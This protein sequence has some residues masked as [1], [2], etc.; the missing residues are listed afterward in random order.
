MM[1]RGKRLAGNTAKR[2]Q[3]NALFG[4]LTIYATKKN[5]RFIH[6]RYGYYRTPETQ[7]E[8]YDLKRSSMDGVKRVSKHQVHLARDIYIINEKNQ[9]VFDV[10]PYAVLGEFW[11]ALGGKW[12]GNFQGSIKADIFHFE[13]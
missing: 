4:E 1:T 10:E 2:A 9:I 5:I 7:R 3:F 13:L 8:L 12:G 11:E 6:D